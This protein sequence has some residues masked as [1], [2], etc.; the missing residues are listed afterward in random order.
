[1][2]P[3]LQTYAA[4]AEDV[5]IDLMPEGDIYLGL[6]ATSNVQPIRQARFI[7]GSSRNSLFVKNFE[8]LQELMALQEQGN[9]FVPLVI[10]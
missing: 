9:K 5:S 2:R 10:P 8:K 3:L 6:S 7:T 4:A 1:M